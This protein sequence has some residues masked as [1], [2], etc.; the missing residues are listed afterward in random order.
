[1]LFRKK[2]TELEMRNKKT[3]SKPQK[4]E[5]VEIVHE[6]RDFLSSFFPRRKRMRKNNTHSVRDAAKN[7]KVVPREKGEIKVQTS[8]EIRKRSSDKKQAKERSMVIS[9]VVLV[10]LFFSSFSVRA[11]K[12][13]I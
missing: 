11:R 10:L 7:I 3:H 13:L 12:E 5:V 1:M 2:L 6:R 8:R 9:N 4:I